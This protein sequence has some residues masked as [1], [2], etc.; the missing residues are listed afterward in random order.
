[1]IKKL[2]YLSNLAFLA[3]YLVLAW[4]NR[5][6]LDDFHFMDNLHR[7]GIIQGTV[8]EYNFYS[9]RWLSVLVVHSTLSLMP[10]TNALFL[11]GIITII[12]I[13]L[14]FSYLLKNVLKHFFAFPPDRLLLLNLA[15]FIVNAFFYSSINIGNIWFW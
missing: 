3:L 8:S 9:T 15:I 10:Y 14:S 2:L 5:L 7:Y 12:G 6:T 4:H 13:I 1:M 11:I